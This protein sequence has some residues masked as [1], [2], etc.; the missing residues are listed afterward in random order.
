[1]GYDPKLSLLREPLG[2]IP[3]LAANFRPAAGCEAS[4]ERTRG[5]RL[6]VPADGATAIF[7]VDH[8]DQAVGAMGRLTLNVLLSFAQFEREVT[9]ERIRDKIAASKK[10][11]MW[12]RGADHQR[13]LLRDQ[14]QVDFSDAE[15]RDTLMRVGLSNL[16]DRLDDSDNWQMRLSGGEQQRLGVARA[17]LQAGLALPRRS[18]GLA[19]RGERSRSLPSDRKNAPKDD[20][21]VDRSSLDAQRLPQA[22]RGLRAARREARDRRERRER[23]LAGRCAGGWP[24]EPRRSLSTISVNNWSSPCG[25]KAGAARPRVRRLRP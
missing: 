11:G 9:G 6:K 7:S 21:G 15:L 8:P 3:K 12:A 1:M 18:D 23:C 5:P 19:R 10:K 25:L 2:R 16:A 24:R 17:A 20:A 22:P 13:R 4:C 14:R